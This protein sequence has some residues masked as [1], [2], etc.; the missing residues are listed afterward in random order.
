MPESFAR[1]FWMSAWSG[2]LLPMLFGWL[3]LV[4]V[5]QAQTLELTQAR[6]SV[7]VNGATS[8]RELQLPY[9]W[10]RFNKGQRGEAVFDLDFDLPEVPADPWGLYL[11]RLGNTYEIWLNGTLLQRQGD[12]LHY[13]GADYARVP[14]FVVI[15]PGLLRSSNLI[16]VHIRADVGRR[17]GL[18]PLV[19]GPQEEVYAAYLRDYFWRGTGSLVVAAFSLVVGLM[20]LSLWATQKDPIYPGQ[21]RCDPLY[22]YAGLAEIFWTFAVSDALIET[23]PLTWPWWGTLQVVAL[24]KPLSSCIL[25]YL[26]G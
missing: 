6:A 15:T 14:R 5:V 12:F 17:G 10:D 7:T 24:G 25:D 4:T 22:L 23:P 1:K 9:H 18:S 26:A 20:A 19:V 11:P 13:N 21:P 8:A 16:R 3:E 2:G